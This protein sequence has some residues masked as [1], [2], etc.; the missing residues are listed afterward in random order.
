MSKI[1]KSASGAAGRNVR[2]PRNVSRDENGCS[3]WMIERS[4]AAGAGM[5]VAMIAPSFLWQYDGRVTLIASVGVFGVV[6]LAGRVVGAVQRLVMRRKKRK[7]T[8]RVEYVTL[9]PFEEERRLGYVSADAVCRAAEYGR[10]GE[11]V[12]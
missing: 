8:V 6:Y 1:L 12:K 9:H 10:N 3:P 11:A 4:D 7:R 5:I 2:E